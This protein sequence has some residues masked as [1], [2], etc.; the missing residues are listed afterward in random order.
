MNFGTVAGPVRLTVAGNVTV[1]AGPWSG[2]ILQQIP[3]A[4][5]IYGPPSFRLQNGTTR[6]IPRTRNRYVYDTRGDGQVHAPTIITA[7]LKV[8]RVIRPG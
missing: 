1:Q 6:R 3:A 7:G 2:A 8:G 4:D 5:P